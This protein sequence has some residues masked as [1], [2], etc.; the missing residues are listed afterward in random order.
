M[1]GI[2]DSG[3]GGLAVLREVRTLLPDADLVYLA[4]QAN[5]PYGDRPLDEVRALTEN[6]VRL[7]I[8]HGATTVV[9]ACNSASAAAIAHVREVFPE[10]PFVG[11]EPAV[12]PAAATSRNG[13]IGVLATAATFAAARF[14]DLVG[15]YA[16]GSTVIAHPCPGWADA[17]E[18]S[19]PEGAAE[20]VAAHLRPLLDAGAD[21]IVLACTHYSFLEETIAQVAGDRVTI[22]NPAH[23]V[24][25]QTERV[26]LETNGSGSTIYLT[27]GEPQRLA[28]QVERL[29]GERVMAGVIR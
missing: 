2:F 26:A 27:T 15:R 12:K 1:I 5:V 3:V 13:V 10:T 23:A 19:W 21:T 22:V 24:A 28:A 6:A 16:E 8:E 9:I 29:L 7:L 25:R 14:E 11:M 20:P 18:E 17:V 4:D